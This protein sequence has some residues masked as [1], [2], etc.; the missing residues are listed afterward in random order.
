MTDWLPTGLVD[1]RLNVHEAQRY[2]ERLQ[3][4]LGSE[5][6]VSLFPLQGGGRMYVGNLTGLAT[7]E[8][9]RARPP[10]VPPVVL[11]TAADGAAGGTPH[12]RR[13]RGVPGG[14]GGG[15]WRGWRAVTSAAAQS[16]LACLD[17]GGSH[18]AGEAV[19]P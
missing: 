16:G 18:A 17:G 8:L 12:G 19:T 5:W 14:M 7:V 9:R 4:A 3:R 11:R 15:T 1:E 13:V 6:R 2:V 10:M